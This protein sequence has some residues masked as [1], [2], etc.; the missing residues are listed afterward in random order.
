MFTMISY[1]VVAMVG[2]V[3]GVLV[4]RNNKNI[5]EN[6]VAKTEDIADAIKK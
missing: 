5:I 1:A 6:V 2:F 3:A 4:G